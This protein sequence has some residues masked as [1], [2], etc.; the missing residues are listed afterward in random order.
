MIRTTIHYR[1][2]VQGVGFR[3]TTHSIARRFAVTGYVRNA[4]DGGVELVAE[5]DAA[6]VDAFLA[7]VSDR[8]GRHIRDHTR[9]DQAATTH[10]H[11]GFTIRY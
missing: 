8:L 3:A 9:H 7:G 11:N 6:E 10:E 5:G 4:A 2:R 1:G